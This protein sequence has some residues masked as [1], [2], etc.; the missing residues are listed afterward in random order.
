MNLLFDP[1]PFADEPENEKPP[2][3]CRCNGESK[4]LMN[5]SRATES[6]MKQGRNIKRFEIRE[7]RKSQG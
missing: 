3:E 6:E 1:L 5:E 2:D 4:C 7:S